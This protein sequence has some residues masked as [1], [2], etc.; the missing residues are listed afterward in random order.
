M[1]EI[2][3][4]GGL[5]RKAMSIMVVVMVMVMILI[6]SMVML[7]KMEI[8]LIVSMVMLAPRSC[9]GIPVR[10]ESTRGGGEDGKVGRSLEA[11][12]TMKTV[13]LGY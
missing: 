5:G 7:A 4:A 6:V 12:D 2:K 3:E 9:L 8:I 1:E 11:K 10:R 13:E